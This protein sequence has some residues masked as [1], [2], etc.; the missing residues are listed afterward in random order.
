MTQ[1]G[2]PHGVAGLICGSSLTAS[3]RELLALQA[4][5]DQHV[6]AG[7]AEASARPGHAQ[8][9]PCATWFSRDAVHETER[10]MLPEFF[11]GAVAGADPEASC[12][13]LPILLMTSGRAKGLEDNEQQSQ[14]CSHGGLL[15]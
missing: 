5:P 2:R 10:Q 3:D 7:D 6:S 8:L 13:L 11:S 9:P 12:M 15:T 1:T 14:S 4:T